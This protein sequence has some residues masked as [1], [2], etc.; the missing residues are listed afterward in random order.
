[1]SAKEKILKLENPKWVQSLFANPKLSVIWLLLR[2]YVGRQWLMAGWA[3]LGNS[4]W[5]GENAGVAVSGFL[6]GAL[7]KASGEHP[8]VQ[9]WYA[10]FVEHVALPNAKVFSYMVSIGE[11]LVGIALILGILTGLAAFFAGFM[12]MNYLLAGTV[13]TNP[14][15]LVSAILIVIAWR[16]AGW[17][18]LDR[19]VLPK[20]FARQIGQ[21]D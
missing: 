9:A 21:K 1:M 18:G 16:V 15:L 4:A 7:S 12:N 14:I 3:K 8:D 5:V 19:W 6:Q 2:L 17:I 13:S 20:L 11:F 10:W